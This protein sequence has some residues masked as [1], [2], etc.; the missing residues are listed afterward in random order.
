MADHSLMT[1]RSACRFS[2]LESV[3]MSRDIVA[4]DARPS[5]TLL[6]SGVSKGL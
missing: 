5:G 4:C 3:S 1:V 6:L 2:E